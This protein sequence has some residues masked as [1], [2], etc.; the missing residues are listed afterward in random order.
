MRSDDA[1]HDHL[2]LFL[3]HSRL[4]LDF[5]RKRDR[6]AGRGVMS[7]SAG[8]GGGETIGSKEKASVLLYRLAAG[9]RPEPRS[10]RGGEN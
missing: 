2:V 10:R 6:D 7:P 1:G 4:P 8:I 5:V 9:P 3:C